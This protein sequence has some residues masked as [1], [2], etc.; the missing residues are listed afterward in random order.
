[1][2]RVCFLNNFQFFLINIY[3]SSCLFAKLCEGM[4]CTSSVA[5]NGTCNCHTPL[6]TPI[7]VLLSPYLFQSPR[8]NC[9]A[10]P[11]SSALLSTRLR[12][13][14]RGHDVGAQA[15]ASQTEAEEALPRLPDDGEG[16][17]EI[18]GGSTGGG[19]GEA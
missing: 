3:C 9:T 7:H 2:V 4:H 15:V 1:M 5:P 13:A 17:N 6:S 19:E 18:G 11:L 14:T 10:T 16:W 12:A 8:Y